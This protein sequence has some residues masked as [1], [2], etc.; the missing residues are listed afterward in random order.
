[1]AIDDRLEQVLT[2]ENLSSGDTYQLS[3][4]LTLTGERNEYES[5]SKRETDTPI[6]G[7]HAGRRNPCRWIA[8]R[9]CS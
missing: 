9:A 3:F 4:S 7:A 6:Y 5:I 2:G 8:R 1:L